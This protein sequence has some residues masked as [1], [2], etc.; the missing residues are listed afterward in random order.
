MKF[1]V[2]IICGLRAGAPEF[3][4]EPEGDGVTVDSE[5]ERQLNQTTPLLLNTPTLAGMTVNGVL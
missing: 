5:N 2:H 3:N 4:D 1:A